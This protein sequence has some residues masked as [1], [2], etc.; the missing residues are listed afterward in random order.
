[1]LL[2]DK[3][4]FNSV[5]RPFR[6]DF[7]TIWGN[8]FEYAD[9]ILQILRQEEYLEIIRIE[10]LRVEDITKFVFD[11]YACD[12]VPIKHLRAKLR[13]L[14][15]VPPEILTVFVRNL[16]PE[17]APAGKGAFRKVQCQY[18]NRLKWGMREI[19][20]PRKDGVRT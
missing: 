11:L 18:I 12:T 15:E 16:A 20:N 17:E 19:F 10:S 14:F 2:S 3:G 1:M 5:K 4:G 9:E 7:F 13:Y 8:A 6:Y